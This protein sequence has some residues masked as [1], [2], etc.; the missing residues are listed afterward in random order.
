MLVVR[1]ER[2]WVLTRRG[3]RPEGVHG[4]VIVGLLLRSLSMGIRRGRV[5][6]ID[7]DRRCWH[8]IQDTAGVLEVTRRRAGIRRQ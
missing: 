6:A 1:A 3:C 5:C 4:Y 7:I 2:A 8:S